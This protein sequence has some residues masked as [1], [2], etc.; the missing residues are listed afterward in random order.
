[1]TQMARCSTV[2]N[3][4]LGVH[5]D[6]PQGQVVR[7]GQCVGTSPDSPGHHHPGHI[8]YQRLPGDVILLLS[9]EGE[10]GP[11]EHPCIKQTDSQCA[12]HG[13]G[14]LDTSKFVSKKS[15]S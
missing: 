11:L 8:V 7:G 6:T 5:F 2:V 15:I 12:L 10:Q 14:I 1:M 4:N 13:Y 3:N 9:Q